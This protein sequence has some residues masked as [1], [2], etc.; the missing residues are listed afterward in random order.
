[1]RYKIKLRNEPVFEV[2]GEVYLFNSSDLVHSRVDERHAVSLNADEVVFIKK[3][4]DAE[5][6]IV[7][8]DCASKEL[9]K[10]IAELKKKGI[11]IDG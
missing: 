11:T 7:K 3:V 6:I 5:P 10:N 4:D 9:A 1:M 2:E 8:V